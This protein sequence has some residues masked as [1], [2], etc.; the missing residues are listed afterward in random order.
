MTTACHGVP[1]SGLCPSRAVN[2]RHHQYL[3]L[4]SP[5]RSVKSCCDRAVRS[6]WPIL[7]LISPLRCPAQPES[8]ALSRSWV[9]WMI[10]GAGTGGPGRERG[11]GLGGE[12]RAR[13]ER[14]GCNLYA[15]GPGPG[16]PWRNTAG[17]GRFLTAGVYGPPAFGLPRRPRAPLS[18]VVVRLLLTFFRSAFLA[19]R[20]AGRS[21]LPRSLVRIRSL[22]FHSTAPVPVFHSHTLSSRAWFPHYAFALPGS[23]SVLLCIHPAHRTICSPS[24]HSP[25]PPLASSHIPPCPPYYYA[26]APACIKSHHRSS[27]A[28][29]FI[30]RISLSPLLLHVALPLRSSRSVYVRYTYRHPINSPS[31]SVAPS[32][33]LALPLPLSLAQPVSP[34]AFFRVPAPA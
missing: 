17:W 8:H 20:M 4:L 21:V 14:G 24:T 10:A 12:T 33:T 7:S 3:L 23:G 6:P 28:P 18:V 11:R 32:A 27:N 15:P 29:V 34:Q 13:R 5:A 26:G 30:L 2:I 19:S 9:L 16:A 1:P 25:P 31:A 22:H